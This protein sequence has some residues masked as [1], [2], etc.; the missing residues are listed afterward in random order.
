[1]RILLNRLAKT[2]RSGMPEGGSREVLRRRVNALFVMLS[3]LYGSD[4]LVLKAGKLEALQLMRSP[5]LRDRLVALQRL[6]WEDPTI[7]DVPA[8]ED[9]PELLAE[10]EDEIADQLARKSV[11]ERIEK[12]IADLMQQRHEDYVRDIKMQVLREDGGP[13]NAYTLKKYAELERLEQRK[14][15]RTALEILRPSSV[16]EV[17]GQERAIRALFSKVV[18]PFP[19]HVILY[20]PPGVGKTTVARLAL[21][22]AKRLPHTPFGPDAPFVE[23]DGA[24]LRWDPR[25]IVNPLLGSVHDPIYQGAR[26]DFA[27]TGVPEPK[28]GLVTEAHGGILFI[29]EIG[30]LDPILQNK[31]L[32]VME[33]KRVRFDSAYYDPD[34]PNVPKYVRKLFEEGAPA[35]FLL[36]GA[37]TRD[38]EEISPALRSRAAEIFFDPLSQADIETI[39]RQAAQKLGVDLEPEVPRLIS[40]Y[41]IEGRKAVSILADAYGVAVYNS[42]DQKAVAQSAAAPAAAKEAPGAAGETVAHPEETVAAREEAAGGASESRPDQADEAA[43]VRPVLPQGLTIGRQHVLDVIQTSRIVPYVTAKASDRPEVGKIF[44]L[45]VW[46]YVGSLLEIEAVVFPA[47][48]SGHGSIRFN[49][50]A[51]SM[52]KDSVFNAASVIRKLT[53]KDLADYDVHI[54]VVGGGRIDGPSAGAAIALAILSAL[55]GWPAAQNVAITGEISI[56]GKVRAVGGIPEKLYGARQAGMKAVLVPAENRAEVPEDPGNLRVVFVSDLEEALPYF[57]PGR[58]LA[59]SGFLGMMAG[60]ADSGAGVPADLPAAASEQAVSEAG[61]A[62][63][64]KVS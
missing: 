58:D 12:R 39:V 51:G 36:I 6:V 48:E 5:Q 26:R 10:I 17:V 64:S 31:L 11:E 37:T 2:G 4:K 33:D 56:Q 21:E 46:G 55:E 15:S 8:D 47:H 60:A 24:T 54:N 35:D 34:D 50:T 52:A 9:I 42:L 62:A 28:L 13:D 16:Q 25:D 29:D 7:E 45:G 59:Q 1:M 44:G 53:G 49:D 57:F 3:D 38:P 23:V 63:K 32:K 61:P 20:G 27:D 30:E 14:L 40:E 19:Q 43:A 22:T 18:S 41:T